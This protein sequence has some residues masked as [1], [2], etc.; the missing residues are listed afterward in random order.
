MQDPKYYTSEAFIWDDLRAKAAESLASIYDC[1]RRWRKVDP[2]LIAWPAQMVL[3]DECKP[4]TGACLHELSGD[5]KSWKTTFRSF[6]EKT[7][8]YALLFA[9]Q[10]EKDVRVII[11]SHHGTRSWTIPIY[12]SG[13][14][15]VLGDPLVEDNAHR[16]GVLWPLFS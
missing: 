8:A 3:D 7:H 14:V 4:I 15:T 13:D 2:F 9:E 10:R 5:P 11:E 16:I 1:W 12:R 6:A